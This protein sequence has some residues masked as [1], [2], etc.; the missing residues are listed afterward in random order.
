MSIV[1]E[2]PVPLYIAQTIGRRHIV[3]AGGGGAA[4]TGIDNGIFFFEI[5]NKEGKVS[6][7]KVKY[8]STNDCAPMCGYVRAQS[9]EQFLLAVP[10]DDVCVNVSLAAYCFEKHTGGKCYR[11]R[12][13]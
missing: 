5:Q 10:K 3:V 9:L 1:G 12:F 2:A 7:E 6:F 11:N 13:N 8:F 4:K